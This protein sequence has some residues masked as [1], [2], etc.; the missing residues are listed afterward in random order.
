MIEKL[1]SAIIS[2]PTN[3]NN[4]NLT[5]FSWKDSDSKGLS[6]DGLP[7]KYDFLWLLAN[8][9]NIKNNNKNDNFIFE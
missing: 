1:S 6:I 5:T 2:G 8:P 3:E 4:E 9:D 7:E